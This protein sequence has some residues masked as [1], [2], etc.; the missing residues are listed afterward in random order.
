MSDAA[1]GDDATCVPPFRAGAAPEDSESGYFGLFD[2]Q[3]PLYLVPRLIYGMP[4]ASVRR[5]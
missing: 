1:L 4:S 5:T 3:L 2:L